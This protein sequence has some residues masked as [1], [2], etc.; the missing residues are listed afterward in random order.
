MFSCQNNEIAPNSSSFSP[1]R[2]AK[3]AAVVYSNNFETAPI[4]WSVYVWSWSTANAV[5]YAGSKKIDQANL[6]ASV[7]PKTYLVKYQTSTAIN[8]PGAGNYKMTFSTITTATSVPNSGIEVILVDAVTRV[9]TVIGTVPL[10]STATPLTTRTINFPIASGSTS[11]FLKL[12]SKAT[13]TT[14]SPTLAG[15]CYFDDI[16]IQ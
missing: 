16:V 1:E 14:T 9:E 13:A 2:G 11:K 5:T 8:F 4:G 3:T 12:V 7:R 6:L 15:H 10:L